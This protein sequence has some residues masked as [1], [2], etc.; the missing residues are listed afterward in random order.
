MIKGRNWIS[1]VAGTTI[2]GPEV[3]KVAI[4]PNFDYNNKDSLSINGWELGQMTGG[5]SIPVYFQFRPWVNVPSGS[6]HQDVTID[7]LC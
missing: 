7:L 4:A 6:F 5:Q 1:D 3:T 2:S